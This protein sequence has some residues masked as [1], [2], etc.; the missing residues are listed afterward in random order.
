MDKGR[1]TA[2]KANAWYREQPWLVGCNFTP[3][4]AINQLEMWQAETFDADTINREL[5]WAAE[6]GFNTARV[7]LHDLVWQANADGF[8]QRIDR[9]LEIAA[10]HGIKTTFVLFD[11]CWN[12]D[13]KL[14]K[15]PDPIPGVHNSGW[16][17][18][19]GT[20]VVTNPKNWERLGAYVRGI[21]GH[22]GADERI[23]MWDLYNEP[24]NNFLPGLSLAWP[25]K[26]FKL[27][28][29]F[30]R[31][32]AFR[33]HSLALLKEIFAWARAAQ[34]TQP[35]T[36]GEW[37]DD[38]ELNAYL[39]ETSDVLTFHN[40]ND[41]EN[42]TNHIARLKTHGRPLIC[43]EYMART[44]GSRFATHLPIFKR[45]Q[46]GCYNWGLVSGKTQTIY[47]W[48][49]KK[50]SA[51]PKVWFHDIFRKDGTPYSVEEVELIKNLA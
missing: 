35:L 7:Y 34:P 3:S 10:G 41:A 50:G 2:E 22:Y 40:Y 36:T 43:T 13:P 24:G 17:Q 14:G 6:L 39:L 44:R 51:E 37:F 21:I 15:Q 11:D 48:G 33:R 1:W 32:A 20:E 25:R 12:P 9:Y 4:T 42:L 47:P 45:E 19:P 5:G 31:R 29:L 23:L 26:A 38:P 18:S 28:F 16:M 8:K 49:S 30:L 46:V 27:I